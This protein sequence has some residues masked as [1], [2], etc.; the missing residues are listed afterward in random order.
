MDLH[1]AVLASPEDDAPR[2]AYADEIEAREPARA[3]LIRIQCELAT[4]SPASPR[5]VPLRLRERALVD[6]HHAKWMK[7]LK[8]TAVY[9]WLRRG[10]FHE[11]RVHGKKVV[12]GGGSIFER[13]PV[14]ALWSRDIGNR[15]VGAFAAMPELARLHKLSLPECKLDAKGLSTLLASPHLTRLRT[16]GLAYN[17]LRGAAAMESLVRWDGIGTLE[18]LALNANPRLGEADLIPL[19]ASERPR[20]LSKLSLG[21]TL[22]GLDG[23]ITLANHL[24]LPALRSL[25]LAGSQ[26]EG[27]D[28]RVLRTCKA[29]S[30]LRALYVEGNP[31]DGLGLMA[32]AQGSWA[33]SLETLFVSQPEDTSCQLAALGKP[34]ALP[35]L[36]RLFYASP[37]LDVKNLGAL[38]QRAGL[39]ALSI[40]GPLDAALIKALAE[41]AFRPSLKELHLGCRS[42]TDP[43]FVETLLEH[44]WPTLHALRIQGAV[45]PRALVDR[46]IAG[47]RFPALCALSVRTES[48]ETLPLPPV[49]ERFF[50]HG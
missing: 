14:R 8:P 35:A 38:S 28:L 36:R 3:E 23:M 5:S 15:V 18:E 9:A 1:A 34:D 42:A 26:L 31:L 16:L 21:G 13:E 20:A 43:S 4:L 40:S 48:E 46:L 12:D 47:G 30:G 39:E 19:L 24:A 37:R 27:E 10:F 6:K 33:P 7:P 41:C 25:S 49:H 11:V 32:I 17:S 22:I 29:L 45:V 44:E 2:L 50:A